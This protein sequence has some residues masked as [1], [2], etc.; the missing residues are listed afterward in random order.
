MYHPRLAWI[1]L[2]ERSLVGALGESVSLFVADDIDPLTKF[3]IIRLGS[4]LPKNCWNPLQILVHAF[5]MSNDSMI[6]KITKTSDT[7]YSA[8]L[9]IKHRSRAV[10]MANDPFLMEDD[11]AIKKKRDEIIKKLRDKDESEDGDLPDDNQ[12]PRF[13]FL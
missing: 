12:C 4:P 3:I 2:L 8:R 1:P 7:T 6:Q 10:E 5:A 11:P 13:V 9:S